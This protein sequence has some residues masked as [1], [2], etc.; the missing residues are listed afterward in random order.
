MR[1]VYQKAESKGVNLKAAKAAMKIIKSEGDEEKIQDIIA[2]MTA[3]IQYL[4]L[5]GFTLTS[6]QLELF[7]FDQPTLQ[8]IDEKA[9]GD[10]LLAGRMGE[11]DNPHDLNS[12]SGRKWAEGHERGIEERKLILSMEVEE[13]DDELIPGERDESTVDIEEELEGE[14]SEL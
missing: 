5:F 4:G 9:F 8:P 13:R 7:K 12:D 2:D 6:Q 10:G 14:A 3:T 1:A 11:V